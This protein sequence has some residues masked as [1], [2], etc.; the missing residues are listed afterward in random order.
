MSADAGDT[1]DLADALLRFLEAHP[2]VRARGRG[3]HRSEGARVGGE[4]R[5]RRSSPAEA[6]CTSEPHDRKS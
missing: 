1:A 4:I 3:V 2:E 6:D 5:T